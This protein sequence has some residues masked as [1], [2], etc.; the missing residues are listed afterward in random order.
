MKLRYNHLGYLPEAPKRILVTD[1]DINTFSILDGDNQVVFTG[2]LVENGLWDHTGEWVRVGDFSSLKTPGMYR[3]SVSDDLKSDVFPIGRDAYAMQLQAAIKGFYFQRSGVELTEERAGKWARPAAHLDDAIP[4]HA[5]ME[6]EGLWNAHGGWYDAGD[7]GKYVVNAGVSVA[8]LMHTFEFYPEIVKSSAL[9]E[10]IRFELDWFLRMQDVDG[11]VFFKVSPDHWDPFVAPIETVYPRRIL[12]KSTASSLNF[13][14]ALAQAHRVF[15]SANAGLARDEMFANL[16]LDCSKKAYEWALQNPHIEYPHN[17]EGS[18]LYNDVHFD[19]EFF[20]AEAE[21][22][23]ETQDN[24]IGERL[25]KRAETQNTLWDINWQNTENLGWISLAMQDGDSSLQAKARTNLENATYAIADGLETCPY[26]VPM[27]HFQWG[28]NGA[29]ANQALTASV[30]LTWNE[31]P[32]FVTILCEA[33]DYLYGR[34]AVNVSFV[35]GSAPSAPK[36][37]HHRLSIGD[38]VEEPVPGLLVGGVNEDRQ[39][40]LSKTPRGLTYPE[41]NS[42]PGTAYYDHVKAYASNEIAIN[43]NAP[44]VFALAALLNQWGIKN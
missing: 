4:F 26:R 9:L 35:T 8:T 6:R 23:R 1:S 42:K 29:L 16:C 34:N 10:E 28:S 27:T 38:Q 7:Y 39:D 24:V 33:L 37:P 43:W 36:F 31:N 44:L 12:G 18:G 5:S 17:T 32:R 19:D 3:I 41:E 13:A 20:W 11:G 2:P 14:G 30:V 21:L 40:D 22:W 25:Q 15:K